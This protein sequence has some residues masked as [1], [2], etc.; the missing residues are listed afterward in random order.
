MNNNY[1]STTMGRV[2]KNGFGLSLVKNLDGNYSEEFKIYRDPNGGYWTTGAFGTNYGIELVI[3][4]DGKRYKAV[5]AVD[6]RNILN[7]EKSSGSSREAG[8]VMTPPSSMGDNVITGWRKDSDSVNNFVLAEP[9][10][11]Y[12]VM[13]G[14]SE[15]E[16]GVIA[17]RF[18]SELKE[19]PPPSVSYMSKGGA[20]RGGA[21]RG[22]GTGYGQQTEFKTTSTNFT[23]DTSLDPV[24]LIII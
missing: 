11:S 16:V 17:V 18:F 21:S 19:L 2:T 3:P 22:M 20:T 8:Y 14:S 1:I 12:A 5:T 24:T 13:T 4:N 23:P 7:G 6:G 15:N 10:Y 9:E